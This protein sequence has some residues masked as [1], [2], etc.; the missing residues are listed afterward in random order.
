MKTL[1]WILAIVLAAVSLSA[2][3]TG[4]PEEGNE[5]ELFFRNKTKTLTASE[6]EEIENLVQQLETL[7]PEDRQAAREAIVRRGSIA[8]PFLLREVMSSNHNRAR[9]ALVALAMMKDPESIPFLEQDVM[10]PRY[11]VSTFAALAMGKI[12]VGVERQEIARMQEVLSRVLLDETGRDAFDRGA[13][14]IALA[15]LG[16]GVD[17]DPLIELL[18]REN[19]I[20]VSSAIL[21]ALGRMEAKEA[22]REIM[23]LATAKS[24]RVAQA[25]ILALGDLGDERAIPFLL[26]VLRSDESPKTLQFACGAISRFDR[27]EVAK[28]LLGFLARPD[29]TKE[30][31]AVALRALGSQTPDPD[32]RRVV[33][34]HLRNVK[35]PP[36]VRAAAIAA[37]HPYADEEI[38]KALIALVRDEDPKVRSAAIILLGHHK[39]DEASPQVA[40]RLEDE[41]REVAEAAALALAN[42]MGVEAQ[43]LLTKASATSR[44]ASFVRNVLDGY[45]RQDWKEYFRGWLQLWVE[46][47]GGQSAGLRRNL[48]NE[49]LYHLFEL[50]GRL[51]AKPGRRSPVGDGDRD[52]TRI[53]STAQQDLLLWIENEP[54]F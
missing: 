34:H 46:G 35:Q 37:I 48:A 49:Q 17:P 52:R 38:R 12:D 9:S 53:L 14:G 22:Y 30:S 16:P 24:E 1:A 11:L 5:I 44:A 3:Q 4:E 39:V 10:R 8:T 51:Y 50:E 32:A 15:R 31:R 25:A 7:H 28:C 42:L 20:K 40:G 33:L 21:M 45:S 6:R 18:A 19:D 43:P 29:I 26:T 13:A 23:K 41:S 36:L 54:Y 27:P 2:A 47:L